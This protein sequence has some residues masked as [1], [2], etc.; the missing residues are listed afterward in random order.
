MIPITKEMWVAWREDSVTK[1]FLTRLANK[2]EQLKEG[3]AEGQGG[4]DYLLY[5]GQ[6]QA[7]RDALAYALQEFEIIEDEDAD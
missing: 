7:Y 1:E 4:E 6:C 5:V 2:R 3:L